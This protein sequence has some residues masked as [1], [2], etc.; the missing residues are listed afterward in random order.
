MNDIV[1][2]EFMTIDDGQYARIP[3][4]GTGPNALCLPGPAKLK[5]MRYRDGRLDHEI[6]EGQTKPTRLALF[7]NMQLINWP[8]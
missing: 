3:N 8:I 4:T 6:I 7:K 5:V 1:A 2:T